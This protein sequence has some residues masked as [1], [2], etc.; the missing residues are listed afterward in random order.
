[1]CVSNHFFLLIVLYVDV[2]FLFLEL[3]IETFLDFIVV[4]IVLLMTS[5]ELSDQFILIIIFFVVQVI[6]LM[7]VAFTR[8][9]VD[10]LIVTSVLIQSILVEVVAIRIVKVYI[11]VKVSFSNT[12]VK[13]EP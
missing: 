4:I 1:M 9:V 2:S 11:R 5:L 13:C 10:T 7:L 3:T 6:K 12:S 8:N